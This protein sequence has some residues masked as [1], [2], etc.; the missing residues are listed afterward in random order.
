M[1]SLAGRESVSK[2]NYK[3]LVH[4]WSPAWKRCSD[5][6]NKQ[7]GGSCKR[8][9][10]TR[11]EDRDPGQIKHK[12][13]VFYHTANVFTRIKM[14]I[15][16]I[17]TCREP[18]CF[19]NFVIFLL[20]HLLCQAIIP[21][22][23]QAVSTS[24]KRQSC[25]LGSQRHLTPSGTYST[26]SHV[27]PNEDVDHNNMIHCERLHTLQN[28]GVGQRLQLTAYKWKSLLKCHMTTS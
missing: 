14:I 23:S 19:I 11:D 17:N 2:W 9:T 26:C 28:S 8:S 27:F 7:E 22:R 16:I 24:L 15:V 12:T 3:Q 5:E 18:L 10:L 1:R 25:H 4:S 13:D 6:D 20:R 21:S